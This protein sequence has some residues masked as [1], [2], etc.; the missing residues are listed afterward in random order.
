[1]NWRVRLIMMADFID[2]RILNHPWLPLCKWI[3]NSPFWSLATA[4]QKEQY[5]RR[6]GLPKGD[7]DEF[8]SDAPT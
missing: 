4:E 6:L 2:A 8:R 3:G 1:M 5:R 7:L